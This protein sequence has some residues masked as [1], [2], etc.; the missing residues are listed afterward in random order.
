MK[1]K[2]TTPWKEDMDQLGDCKKLG[3]RP[4]PVS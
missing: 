4:P 1:D 3:S 2:G